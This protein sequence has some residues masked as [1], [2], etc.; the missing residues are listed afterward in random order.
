MA[1]IFLE[2]TH[3][4]GHWYPSRAFNWVIRRTMKREEALRMRT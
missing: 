4:Q 3:R 1:N 2:I